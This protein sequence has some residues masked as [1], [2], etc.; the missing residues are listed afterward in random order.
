MSLLFSYFPN[1]S[2]CCFSFFNFS[3]SDTLFFSPLTFPYLS[4]KEHFPTLSQLR[5]IPLNLYFIASH[6]LTLSSLFAHKICDYTVICE[7]CFATP[8]PLSFFPPSVWA[9]Y[10]WG[11][12][13]CCGLWRI[14]PM[15]QLWV[16]PCVCVPFISRP[17]RLMPLIAHHYNFMPAYQLFF[18][19]LCVWILWPCY[20][21]STLSFDSLDSSQT[22]PSHTQ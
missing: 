14:Y 18:Y 11:N 21:E 2:F 15:A 13:D 20:S 7:A 1:F 8:S 4:G 19:T 16:A 5:P 12:K 9:G 22:R 17:L 10:Q 3:N 6:F